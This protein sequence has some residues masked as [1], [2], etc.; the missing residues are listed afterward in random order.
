MDEST[1]DFDPPE[2]CAWL[3]DWFWELSSARRHGPNGPDPIT[4][5]DILVWSQMT[6][7]QLLREEIG[8]IRSMDDAF[9][10]ALAKE[11]S[12]QREREG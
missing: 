7:N 8:I 6:G 2:D 10:G 5:H 4:Y 11:R 3:W 9:L 12:E 1:P